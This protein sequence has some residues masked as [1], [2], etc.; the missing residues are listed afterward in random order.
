MSLSR[1]PTRRS[2]RDWRGAGAV[3][4]G[5]TNMPDLP[6]AM[7]TEAA[8]SAA[9][10]RTTT[11]QSRRVGGTDRRDGQ[12][13]NARHRHRYRQLHSYAILDERGREC[14]PRAGLVSIAGIAPLDWLLD[15][16]GQSRTVTDAAIALGVMAGP[17]L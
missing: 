2:S 17:I 5:Q 12:S 14:F 3:I 10:E 1:L 6:P 15:N 13:R 11:L 8:P 4:I 9:W 7:S 16:T